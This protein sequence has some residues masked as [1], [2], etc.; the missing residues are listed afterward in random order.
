MD[1][2]SDKLSDAPK[3]PDGE[4]LAVPLEGGLVP[5][6][7]R[8]DAEQSEIATRGTK[9][10]TVGRTLWD[11]VWKLAA[12]ILL[13][14]PILAV[15]L[16]VGAKLDLVDLR[17]DDGWHFRIGVD[18][19]EV[20]RQQVEPDKQAEQEKL[21]SWT[22]SVRRYVG[23]FL[24]NAWTTRW[25]AASENYSMSTGDSNSKCMWTTHMEITF[26]V[27]SFDPDLNRRDGVA[28]FS[29][30][31]NESLIQSTARSNTRIE[32]DKRACR[33]LMLEHIPAQAWTEHYSVFFSIDDPWKIKARFVQTDCDSTCSD[34]E[35]SFIALPTRELDYANGG[36]RYR[37]VESKPP[38][39]H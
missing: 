10:E 8:S 25:N 24:I 37:M 23:S 31:S 35:R 38:D 26:Q 12:P 30:N 22:P 20:Q 14:I 29:S 33:Q 2:P 11:A 15:V 27:K 34:T 36:S 18:H 39:A 9:N 4:R 3:K 19:R 13:C 17:Y 21:A 32:R 1:S 28:T 16:I 6:I 7:R 5:D